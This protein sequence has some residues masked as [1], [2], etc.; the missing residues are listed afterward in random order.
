MEKQMRAKMMWVAALSLGMFAL[1]AQAQTLKKVAHDVSST[2]KKA[3][4]D[5]KAEVHRD[6]SKAHNALTDAGN[7]TKKAAGD[8]TGIH[9]VGGDVGK[10]AR[11]VSHA[12]KKAGRST[13]KS[14][15]SAKSD[16]HASLTKTGKDAKKEVKTP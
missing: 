14:V 8:A 15:N 2:V 7:D 16:A 12:S 5:T 6:A 9:K 3:G 11:K 13:R 10:A 1:P 4:R